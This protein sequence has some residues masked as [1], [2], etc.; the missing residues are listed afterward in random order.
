MITS[1]RNPQ[2]A[3]IR[4]LHKRGV[5]DA[6]REFLIE[7]ANG[8]G[9]ALQTRAPLTTIFVEGTGDGFPE[10]TRQAKARGVPVQTISEA[11]MRAISS[12]TTPPGIV[13]VSRF[14]DRDPVALLKQEI[15][16]AVVL[17]GVR[18]PGNAGT[19]IRSCTAAGVEAVFLG[20]ATVDVYNPKFVRATAGAMFNLPFARNVEIPWLLK[21]LG[22]LDLHR[23]AAD[24]TGEAVYD[25]V[26]FRRRTAFVLGNEA[27]GVP[28][29]L[30]S[31]VDAR[32]SIPMSRSV[33]SLNVGMA[34]TVL[35][36]EAARQRRSGR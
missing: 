12:A 3:A 28:V 29:E 5:R 36:F 21:E 6:R 16:L 17:A 19:I 4:K 27:W 15:T 1:L 26:D 33:E 25:Q 9:Q 20:E 34:A 8:V 35:L 13:G 10:L 22:N 23:V 18:D 11:V 32:V 14:V 30:A 24:P 31:A 7:G 2:I